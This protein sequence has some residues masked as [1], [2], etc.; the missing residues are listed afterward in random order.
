MLTE[1][2]IDPLIEEAFNESDAFVEWFLSKT[3]FRGID[4][5]CVW[6]RSDHP[7]GRFTFEISDPNTGATEQITRD[8]E[9]DVL[10]VLEGTTGKRFAFHIENKLA[11]GHFTLHQPDMYK[12]RAN[13]WLNDDKF[14]DYDDFETVLISPLAF[15]KN[16][17]EA[18]K[19]FDRYISYEEASIFLPELSENCVWPI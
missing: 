1:K 11:G 2:Q 16:N 17:I 15:Y 6:S 9:T 13:S 3:K 12:M 5:K 19:P 14:G 18:A 4:A 7:W 8:S 10:V